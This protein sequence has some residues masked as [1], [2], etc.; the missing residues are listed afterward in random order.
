M[1]YDDLGVELAYWFAYFDLLLFFIDS[2]CEH[3]LYDF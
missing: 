2:Y 1:K 3:L